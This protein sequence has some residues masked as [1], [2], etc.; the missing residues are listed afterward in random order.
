[1]KKTVIIISFITLVASCKTTKK[2]TV[3]DS[4]TT[5]TPAVSIEAPA[6]PGLLA[7]SSDGIYPPG[8]AEL[9]AIQVKYKEATLAQLQEGHTLYTKGACTNCHGPKNIY[10]YNEL[11]WKDIIDDM[12]FKAKITALEKDAVSKYVFAIKAKQP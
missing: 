1:M 7:K 3:A 10:R 6:G 5:T 12:A 4:S 11:A 8:E 2:S 9:T